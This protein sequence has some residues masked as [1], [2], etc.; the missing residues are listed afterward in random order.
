MIIFFFTKSNDGILSIE[1][2]RVD[3]FYSNLLNTAEVRA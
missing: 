3:R 2:K 1:K